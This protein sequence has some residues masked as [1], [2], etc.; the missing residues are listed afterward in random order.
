MTLRDYWMGTAVLLSVALLIVAI[1]APVCADDAEDK[2][3]AAVERLGGQVLRDATKPGKPVRDVTISGK[4]VKDADLKDLAG[5]KELGWL[6]LH[7][8]E[9]TDAGLKELAQLKQL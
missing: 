3:L 5:F 8:S 6:T 4:G 1:A 7:N 2:A 9:V